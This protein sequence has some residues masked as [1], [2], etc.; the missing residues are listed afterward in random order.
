M[1]IIRTAQTVPGKIVATVTMGGGRKRQRTV[2]IDTDKGLNWNHGNAAGELAL[3]VDLVWH[4]SIE[5]DHNE[6]MDRHGFAWP[7]DVLIEVMRE[8]LGAIRNHG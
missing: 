5:H 2:A 6:T 8:A 7:T 1:Y 3:A 4:P